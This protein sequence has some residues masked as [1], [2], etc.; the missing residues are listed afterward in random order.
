MIEAFSGY[1]IHFISA[2]GY[3]G[4]F[5]LMGL[6]SSIIPFPSEVT[7][8]FSGFLVHAGRLNYFLVILIEIKQCFS[9]NSFPEDDS[10]FRYRPE[11]LK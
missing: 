6:G 3:A 2:S 4:I 7:L 11:Y 5:F 10:L 1:I 9:V 8:P